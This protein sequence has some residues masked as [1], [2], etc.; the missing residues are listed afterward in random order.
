M[1]RSRPRILVLL[2]FSVFPLLQACAT[3]T[4]P[5]VETSA[6]P[7]AATPAVEAAEGKRFRILQIND[8][9]KIEGLEG[10]AV[11][12]LAR[13]RTLRR[14]LETDR[15]VL[16]LHAGDFLFPS[17]MSKQFRGEAMVETMNLLDG[18]PGFDDHLIVT[19]GN[20]EFDQDTPDTLQ[21]RLTE[22]KFPWISSNTYYKPSSSAPP[23]PF[24]R[25]FPNV[26]STMI[27]E[28][29]GT[30][31]GLLGLTLDDA[32]KSYVHYDY[33]LDEKQPERSSRNAA[34]RAALSHLEEQGVD[35]VIAVTHQ[36]F[37]QDVRL[38]QDFPEIAL[39]IGGHDHIHQER[40]VGKTLITKADSDAKTAY[41]IDVDA[42]IPCK[43]RIEARLLPLDKKVEKDP[44]VQQT[45]NLWTEKLATAIPDYKKVYSTTVNALE[46]EEPA[47]R[48]RETALGNWLADVVREKMNTDVVFIQG[49][50]IR[51]NDNIPAKGEIRGEHLAGIF[52]YDSLLY[53]FK[54]T[55]QQLLDVLGN[56]VS[57]ADS[58]A[59]R[60]LQVAGIRFEYKPVKDSFQVTKAEVKRVGGT[61]YEPI[62]PSATYTASTLDYLWTNGYKEGFKIFSKGDGKGGQSPALINGTG[63]AKIAWRK[64]TEDWMAVN[65]QVTTAIEGR[66]VRLKVEGME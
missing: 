62:D 37:A 43:P 18:G 33:A 19:F 44:T 28:V 31:V 9:Y 59:G 27:V 61:V 32:L 53:S 55:G 5:V 38:A 65:P 42:S 24:H 49:G 64:T 22:S 50:S 20:H 48:G 25:R 7:V 4:A 3:S 58:G 10:G 66:I 51:I 54:L 52:Y 2:L 17:V 21:T 11:G 57:Q 16:L 30:R 12:G 23:E 1:N 29:A 8:V 41:V 47:I 34:V 63:E 15:P 14:T 40:W 56:A 39:I 60:F 6:T 36:E 35:L 26:H 45:V 46:G 13:V